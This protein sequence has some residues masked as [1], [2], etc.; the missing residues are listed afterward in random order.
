MVFNLFTWSLSLSLNIEVKLLLQSLVI[1]PLHVPVQTF[2]TCRRLIFCQNWKHWIR[3][4]IVVCLCRRD[5]LLREKRHNFL[6]FFWLFRLRFILSYRTFK[7][8]NLTLC[9]LVCLLLLKRARILTSFAHLQKFWMLLQDW[10]VVLDLETVSVGVD[11]R[12]IVFL[13]K[14]LSQEMVT[15]KDL[16]TNL[17]SLQ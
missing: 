13:H 11:L 6:R 9:A 16:F 1:G 3:L 15:A 14:F 8:L 7:T 2:Y 5:L 17:D 4:M 10:F 12:L